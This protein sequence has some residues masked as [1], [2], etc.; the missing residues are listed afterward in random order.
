M[1]DAAV[2]AADGDGQRVQLP[3]APGPAADGQAGWGA[4]PLVRPCVGGGVCR[5]RRHCGASQLSHS[6]QAGARGKNRRKRL[7]ASSTLFKAGPAFSSSLP[8]GANSKWTQRVRLLRRKV[9]RAF[10]DRNPTCWR[11]G[12]S[13]PHFES[14]LQGCELCHALFEIPCTCTSRPVSPSL[15]NCEIMPDCQPCLNLLLTSSCCEIQQVYY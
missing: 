2:L 15:S 9:N 10:R 7:P 4:L 12:R 5:R 11:A 8:S 1:V 3:G 6:N 13:V 14:C